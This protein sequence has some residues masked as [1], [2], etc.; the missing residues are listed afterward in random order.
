MNPYVD[1]TWWKRLFTV[2]AIALG[3]LV[4]G[5]RFY[6][7]FTSPG[8][9][10]DDLMWALFAAGICVGLVFIVRVAVSYIVEGLTKKSPPKLPPLDFH[11]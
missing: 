9:K 11:V 3:S 10:E 8:F 1:D 4:G 7:S 6:R 5:V 2:L